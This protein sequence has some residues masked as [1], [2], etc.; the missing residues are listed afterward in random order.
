LLWRWE[1]ALEAHSAGG[2]TVVGLSLAFT[3]RDRWGWITQIVLAGAI[4]A[5]ALRIV[6]V[7]RLDLHGPLHRL[8]VMDPLCGGTRAMF[9]LLS[10]HPREAAMYN[11]IVFPLVAA[12]VV[13]VVRAGVGRLTGRWVDVVLTAG[14]RRV[15][16]AACVLALIALEVRQQL[17]APLLMQTWS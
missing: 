10:G 13:L 16:I 6:G 2:R 17:H 8:G 14:S 4:V 1:I 7:P 11:P 15:L 3:R 12:M 9:L 5:V